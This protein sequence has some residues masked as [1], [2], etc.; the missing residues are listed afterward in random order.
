MNDHDVAE[1]AARRGLDL[2]T[3]SINYFSDSPGHGILFGYAA[4]NEQEITKAIV[5]LRETFRD[6]EQPKAGRRRT[7]EIV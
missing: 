5:T 6:I 1:A 3:V 2:Q 7:S 4:L